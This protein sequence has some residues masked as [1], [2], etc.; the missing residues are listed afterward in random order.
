MNCKFC[1]AELESNSSV[2]PACGKDNLTDAPKDNLKG[3]KIAALVMVC[4]VMLVLLAALVC[5]GITGSF[6]PWLNTDPTDPSETEATLSPEEIAFNESMKE[7]VATMGDYE[8]TNGDL[9]I[10]YWLVAYNQ[11][12]LDLTTPL[13]AQIYDEETGTTYHDFCIEEGVK[14]WQEIMMMVQAAKDA[15]YELDEETQS[16]IDGMKEEL[17]YYVYIY[18]YYGYEISTVDELVQMQFGP[19]ANY[20]NYYNYTYNYYYGGAYWSDMLED[21]DISDDEINSY[22]DKNE[23]SLAKDYSLAITKD[24]GDLYD[25][26]NIFIAVTEDDDGNKDWDTC[27]STAQAVYDEWLAGEKTEASFIALVEEHSEDDESASNGGLYE[28]VYKTSLREVDVRHILIMPEDDTAEEDW[29]TAKTTAE[30]ILNQ[31]LAGDMTEES[32]A[33]LAEEKSE[34]EGS[35]AEGGLYEDV[36]IGQMVTEFEDWCFDSSRQNG[37]YGIVKTEYGYHIM[38]FVR[39]DSAMDDWVTG[40]DR[41]PGNVEMVKTDT[42]YQILYFVGSEPAWYRYSRYGAQVEQAQTIL[43]AMK[44]KNPYTV[45]YDSV[46]IGEIETE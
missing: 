40:E 23:E 41:T 46:V 42:G 12:D 1:N 21:I 2:C 32:F 26:R 13:D 16:Y 31:W 37:D 34:D 27:L 11:E 6:T 20:D 3:L 17:E 43:D 25:I 39:S 18:S 15:G 44:E 4:V 9:Q 30:D 38:Y 24:F 28:D 7:V 14:A 36:Y 19:G 45:A 10:Y 22:F 33:A 29:N 35:S 8:L 5:Y